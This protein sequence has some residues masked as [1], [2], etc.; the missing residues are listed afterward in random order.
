LGSET[1][2][3]GRVAGGT[4]EAITV[5]ISGAVFPVEA[6]TVGLQSNHAHI[7]DA[8]TGKRIDSIG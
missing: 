2:V 8:R 1:L 6:L 4:G 7:F 3:H 5:R